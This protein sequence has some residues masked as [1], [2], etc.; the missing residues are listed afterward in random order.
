MPRIIAFPG[1][2]TA[3][4]LTGFGGSSTADYAYRPEGNRLEKGELTEFLKKQIPFHERSGSVA[5]IFATTNSD[6]KQA[7]KELK[8][9][10][11]IHTRAVSKRQHPDK[12]LVGWHYVVGRENGEPVL[13]KDVPVLPEA[14]APAVD[15]FKIGDRVYIRKGLVFNPEE[16]NQVGWCNGMRDNQGRIG[17]VD[18]IYTGYDGEKYYQVRG[19]HWPQRFL[20]KR[21]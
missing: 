1:C 12:D 17:L 19:Y 21:G 14:G 11:F 7:M 5:I 13:A 2:C 20:I 8:D 10:G 18:R 15:G 6:Q 16:R 4:I 9:F 3:R